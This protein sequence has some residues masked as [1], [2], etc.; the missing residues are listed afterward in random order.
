[1]TV[2]ADA[3]APYLPFIPFL[4]QRLVRLEAFLL[5][6]EGGVDEVEVDVIYIIY[7]PSIVREV[8]VKRGVPVS[9]FV[10]LSSTTRSVDSAPCEFW[11]TFVAKKRRK[12]VNDTE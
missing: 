9:S 6:G 7:I 12:K 4:E 11:M 2:I 3:D 10:R 1:M 8:Q 5:P